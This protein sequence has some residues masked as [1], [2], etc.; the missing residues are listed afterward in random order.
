[1]TRSIVTPLVIL[2]TLVGGCATQQG[3]A[4]PSSLNSIPFVQFGNIENWQADG[5]KGIYVQSK[6]RYWY[7][8]TFIAPCIDL[9]FTEERIGFRT[10]PPMPMDKFD[11][12]VVRGQPCYFKTFEKL[13]GPPSNNVPKAPPPPPPAM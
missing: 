5:T 6:D 13:P 4:S 11:S 7:Y 3:G 12:I 9:P 2:S 8:A 1:M 10:T